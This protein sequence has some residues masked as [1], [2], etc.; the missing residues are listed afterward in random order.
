MIAIVLAVLLFFRR[1][2]WPHGAVLGDIDG[3]DGW[4]S[5]EAFPDAQELP[6]IV[7]YR[8]EAPL[9]FANAGAFRRRSATSCGAHEPRW[10]VA[11]VRGD[12]RHRR[13]RGRDA[14]AARRGAQRARAST[15]R[16]SRCAAALQDLAL[17]LRPVRDPRPR[18]LLPDARRGDRGGPRPRTPAGSR[19]R[20]RGR[21]RTGGPTS[22]GARRSRA[23]RPAIVRNSAEIVH[24]IDGGASAA[25]E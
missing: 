12:H 14:R 11:P 17:Q 2:W 24:H 20:R 23:G 3:L 21:S 16:S 6:G 18:P 1:S 25:G 7:V 4:H 9:F 15:W 10:V 8:W 13:H 5:I 22:A 19:H